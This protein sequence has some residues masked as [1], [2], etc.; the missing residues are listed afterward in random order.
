VAGLPTDRFCFEGFPPRKA[1]ER[2][3]RFAALS[4]ESRTIVFFES[5]RRLA[6]TLAELAAAFGADRRGVACR[7]LTKTH[8]EIRRGTLGDLAGWSASGVLGEITLVVAGAP[9]TKAADALAM[10]GG[11]AD[12]TG[13]DIAALVAAEQRDGISRKDAITRV[14]ERLGRPRREVYAAAVHAR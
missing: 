11:A 2:A 14:A 10:G 1:G 12:A 9:G 6:S 7:E 4:R 3:R 13:A 5:P 8:E